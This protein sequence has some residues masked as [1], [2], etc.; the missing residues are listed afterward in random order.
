MTL[1]GALRSYFRVGRA[2]DNLPILVTAKPGREKG[3]H[4]LGQVMNELG[5][6]VGA[7]IGTRYGQSARIWCEAMPGLDLTCID[8][9]VGYHARSQ[10]SQ[11][12][13]YEGAKENAKRFGFKLLKLKSLEA[14]DRFRDASLDF[15]NIDGDHTFDA[16]VQDIIRWTPKVRPG[17]LILCHDYCVFKRCGV[18][19]AIDA[20]THCHKIEPWYV[21]RQYEP[22]AFWERGTELV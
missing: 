4:M 18:M 13:V 9:Y 10:A 12:K 3:R 20:Y 16:A 19:W 6:R 17:G 2:P 21:T 11:D 8:P 15:V 22:T 14:V 7:E 5:F 1:D